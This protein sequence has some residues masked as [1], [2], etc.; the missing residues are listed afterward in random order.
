MLWLC[1]TWLA[2]KKFCI[3]YWKALVAF[4]LILVGYILGRKNDNNEIIKNDADAKV[5]SFKKQL[6]DA[7]SLNKNHRKESEELLKKK[8]KAIQKIEKTK[9]KNI[10]D[11]S[12]KDEKLDK[13]LKEKYNLKKG[14]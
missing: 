6:E 9:E 4:L 1:K 8:E 7:E 5:N 2:I 10:K 12:N 11:L 14:E 13:I 3:D